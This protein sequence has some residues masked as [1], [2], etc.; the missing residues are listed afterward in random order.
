MQEGHQ[1]STINALSKKFR[2]LSFASKKKR[3]DRTEPRPKGTV[4]RGTGR[5]QVYQHLEPGD[6]F[7]SHI[8][9]KKYSINYE[10]DCICSDVVYLISCKT[11][12]IPTVSWIMDLAKA[13]C[14]N[15]ILGDY[16]TNQRAHEISLMKKLLSNS[17]ILGYLRDRNA[18]AHSVDSDI[19]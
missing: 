9:R 12:Q 2:L 4:R 11:C 3:T 17:V 19:F 5:C 15:G 16:G 10:L 13:F 7:T 14:Y 1:G 18:A 8:I 6:T